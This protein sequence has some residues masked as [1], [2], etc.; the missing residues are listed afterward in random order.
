[1]TPCF[2]DGVSWMEDVFEINKRQKHTTSF[3][4]D[5]I[6]IKMGKHISNTALTSSTHS[7]HGIPLI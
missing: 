6:H 1:M 3:T 7:I 2:Q 5:T 4:K